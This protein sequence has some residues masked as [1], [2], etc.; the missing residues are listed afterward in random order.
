MPR[1]K[2]RFSEQYQNIV[3]HG[4]NKEIEEKKF[5]DELIK[6]NSEFENFMCI[7]FGDDAD[8]FGTKIIS[9]FNIENFK[10][11]YPTIFKI[12]KTHGGLCD[13]ICNYFTIN[14]HTK[15]KLTFNNF[16]DKINEFDFA[17][18]ENLSKTHILS[19]VTFFELIKFVL[20]NIIP[21]N[22]FTWNEQMNINN[23]SVNKAILNSKFDEIPV[24][25]CIKFIK[26]KTNFLGIPTTG[27]SML[28]TKVDEDNYMFFNPDSC[29]PEFNFFKN[30]EL[31]KKIQEATLDYPRIALIDNDDF[32]KRVENKI[33][34]NLCEN[35][36]AHEEYVDIETSTILV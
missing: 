31:T 3:K 17:K 30:E 32:M 33:H 28:I 16:K 2:N 5:K 8:D 6:F 9:D 20:F 26:F 34:N 27:H 18:I 1:K 12:Y 21:S 14:K 23:N 22:I 13:L 7:N 19:L 36:E 29:F 25:K 24:G 15:N 11:K 35:Y 4:L 10:K